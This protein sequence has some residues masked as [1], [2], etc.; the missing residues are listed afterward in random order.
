[1]R[2][3]RVLVVAAVPLIGLFGC[4]GDRPAADAAAPEPRVEIVAPATGDTVSVPF[5]VRLQAIGVEVVPASGIREE[6]KG[7]H[8]LLIDSDLAA[9]DQP[10]PAGPRWI[11]VGTGAAERVV[12]SL[13]P[14]PHR[15]IAVLGY[16]DHVPMS[17]VATDT[18]TVI[19]R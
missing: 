7:H 16:G 2:R 15:I 10:I 12:D 8:H 5:T 1:M 4:K 13:S 11:H 6:G 3:A 18:I 9:L 19:V 17:R 14:G